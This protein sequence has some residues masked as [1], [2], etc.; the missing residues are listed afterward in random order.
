MEEGKAHGGWLHPAQG[1]TGKC[2]HDGFSRDA[3]IGD[4]HVDGDAWFV[5]KH[6]PIYPQMKHQ[7][8]LKITQ[9]LG[10]T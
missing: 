2:G 8:F 9:I 10:M 7:R 5:T 3:Q 6:G 4:A 1:S